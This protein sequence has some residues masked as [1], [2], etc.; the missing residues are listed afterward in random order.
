MD[1]TELEIMPG[2][3]GQLTDQR[4][5]RWEEL[6]DLALYMDQVLALMERYLGDVPGQDG[7]SL[8]AAMVNNY[9]KQGAI[10]APERKK[11]SRRHLVHLIVICVLK[12]VLPIPAICRFIQAHLAVM[13]EARFLDLFGDAL[14]RANADAVRAVSREPEPG[15]D[16]LSPACAA[17]LRARAEQALA[18]AL[19]PDNT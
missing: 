6:P 3:C 8:T 12:P 19:V 5:P 15:R 1:T 18:L 2:V 9:V 16:S 4:L 13:D 7:R 10:P 14:C 11:Y 17:A